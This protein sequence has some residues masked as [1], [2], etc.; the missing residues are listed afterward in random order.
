M[1]RLGLGLGLGLGLLVACGR[2]A[3]AHE[4]TV[5]GTSFLLDGA[6]FPFTGVS[7]FNAIYNKAFNESRKARVEWLTRFKRY[8]INVLR[9]WGQWDTKRG[10]ADTCPTCSLFQMDGTL[11]QEH[12]LGLQAILADADSQGMVIE[13]A[14]LAQESWFGGIRIGPAETEKAIAA[15]TRALAPHRNVT[16]QIWNELTERTLEYVA[17]IKAADPKRL[18]TSSPGVAGILGDLK[19]NE[20]LDYLTPHT[21]RQGRA[22]PHWEIAPREIA[23]LQERFAKPVV[24]DEPARNGTASFGG[25]KGP[26]S[27]IDHILQIH[28]VWRLGGYVIYHHDMF[29]TGYGSKS[30]PPHGIPDPEW[31]PYH[32]AVFEFLAQRKRY[33]GR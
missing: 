27:P 13:L 20:A 30:V 21:T 19:Q 3:A 12:V 31:S 25:P 10:Y 9:V 29:Q 15:L 11:R 24:D 18:V 8:G 32:R 17:V 28:A 2:S 23:Y 5:S 1:R 6:P 22:R 26:T 4:L 14:L 33:A 7:F 16:L